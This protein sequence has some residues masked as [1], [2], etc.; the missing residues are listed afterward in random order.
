MFPHSTLPSQN[1]RKGTEVDTTNNTAHEIWSAIPGYNGN[2]YASNLGRIKSCIKKERI[3]KPRVDQDGYL[4]IRLTVGRRHRKHIFVHRLVMLTFVGECP[5]NYQVNHKNGI[6]SDNRLEN[7]E[8]CTD[9]QNKRHAFD[10]G[11]RFN[12]VGAESHASKL[13]DGKVQEIKRLLAEG[14]EGATI[15]AMF[16]MSRA[17]ISRIKTGKMWGHVKP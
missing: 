2:F 11:L 6:K 3:L 7:L 15:A 10:T 1:S 12:K 4:R 14:V 13:T 17:Q 16:G 5:P 8:Y 9:S